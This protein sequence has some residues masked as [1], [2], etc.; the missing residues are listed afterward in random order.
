M[1]RDETGDDDLSDYVRFAQSVVGRVLESGLVQALLR[2]DADR[3]GQLM[4]LH[5][6]VVSRWVW[7]IALARERLV[8]G[9]ERMAFQDWKC[10]EVKD[11]RRKRL[12]SPVILLC[13][14]SG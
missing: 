1:I 8:T 13:C 14:S 10:H 6:F 2:V 12:K 9:S 4:L 5:A 11:R 7:E 3:R